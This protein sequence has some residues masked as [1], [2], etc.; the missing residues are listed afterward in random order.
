MITSPQTDH[1]N[2]FSVIELLIVL[3]IVSITASLAIPAAV[4]FYDMV[5]MR[6][7]SSQIHRAIA[8]TKYMASYTGKA[9]TFCPLDLRRRCSDDWSEE[10]TIFTDSN[11]NDLLDGR[12]QILKVIPQVGSDVYKREFSRK[13]PITFQPFGDAFGHNGIFRICRDD[14]SNYLSHTVIIASSGRIRQGKDE[15]NDGLAEDSAGDAVKC[16]E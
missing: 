1:R 2:G 10:I 11:Q 15:N 13:S 12:E 5:A 4:A 9:T 7:E 16:S 3:V 6:A 8:F 14:D